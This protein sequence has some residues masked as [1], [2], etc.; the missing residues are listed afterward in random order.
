MIGSVSVSGET[1]HSTETK[2]LWLAPL[3]HC[4]WFICYWIWPSIHSKWH[5]IK[6]DVSCCH[7]YGRFLIKSFLF[8]DNINITSIINEFSRISNCA[9]W[10]QFS[11]ELN[12]FVAAICFTILGDFQLCK[13]SY[14]NFSLTWMLLC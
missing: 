8:K 10:I 1:R 9:S 2:C 3:N 13:V 12:H 4:F 14:D 6:I 5:N 11:R 7:L